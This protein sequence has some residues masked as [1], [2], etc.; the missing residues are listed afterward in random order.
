MRPCIRFFITATPVPVLIALGKEEDEMESGG[1][2]YRAKDIKFERTEPCDDYVGVDEM[3]S[4]CCCAKVPIT[5]HFKVAGSHFLFVFK[6]T[7][8]GREREGPFHQKGRAKA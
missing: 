2:E 8:S 7:I 1:K 5:R 4:S 3:V 6:A